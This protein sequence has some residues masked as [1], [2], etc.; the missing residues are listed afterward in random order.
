MSGQRLVLVGNGMAGL[1][2]IDA[3]LQ[4]D[5]SWQASVF[6]DEPVLGYNRILLSSVLAGECSA[7]ETITHDAAWYAARGIALHAGVRIVAIDR[8]CRVVRDDTGRETAFD[9][10]ILATGSEAWVPPIEGAERPGVHVFRTLGDTAA[11]LAEGRRARRA[12]VIGGG[13]LGLEAARGLAK[14]GI[15][16]CVVHLMPWLMEQQ[17]DAA[18]GALLR[19]AMQRL[20]IRVLL[21]RKT[22]RLEGAAPGA[23]V[24][25]VVLE[26]DETLAADLVV[27][28]AGIRPRVELARSAGLD[29]KRGVVVDDHLHTSDA[30]ISAVGECVEHR[31]RCYGLVAPRLWSAP[32]RG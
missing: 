28:A 30:A 6:G 15:D 22:L 16:T 26:G 8:G 7:E 11:I 18:A 2:C 10:L 5:P 24:E 12:V 21:E 27:I 14:R 19:D 31:G 20:S 25:R 13:L 4:R 1:A 23:R 32:A 3:V 17:L 9:R 29:V